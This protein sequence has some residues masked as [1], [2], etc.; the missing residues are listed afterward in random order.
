MQISD[1]FDIPERPDLSLFI[2]GIDDDNE[3]TVRKNIADFVVTDKLKEGLDGLLGSAGGMLE[4][5]KDIGRF[6]YGSFGSGKSHLMTI[7]GRMLGRKEIVYDLGRPALRELQARHPWMERRRCLVVRLNMMGKTSL[8]HALYE[9]FQTAMAAERPA[10]ARLDFTD[11][12]EVFALFEKDAAR[13]GGLGPALQQVAADNALAEVGGFGAQMPA[14]VLERAYHAFRDGDRKKRLTLAAA[15]LT[16]RN[17]GRVVRPDDL[18]VAPAAGFDRMARQAQEQGFDTIVWMIDELVIWLRGQTRDTYVSQINTLSAMV[19]H[20]SPRV[21]PFFVLVAVQTDISETC[22]NDLSE[23][24]FREQLSFISNRFRPA[25]HLEEQDLYEVCA[26]RVL[27]PRA[28]LPPQRRQAMEQAIDASFRQHD[29]L[30]RLLC[31]S[32]DLARVRR[33]YPFHP[34]ILRVLIDVTQALSRNRTAIAAL[35]GMLDAHRSLPIGRFLPLAALW[36]ILFIPDNVRALD[37]NVRSELSQRLS[38]TVQTWERLAGKVAAIS[39]DDGLAD[40]GTESKAQTELRQ[41]LRTAL[42]CQL[43]ERPYFPDGRA[44]RESVTGGTL[45]AFAQSEISSV[46][47]ATG[48]SR[49]T[50]Q[51][52]R[53]S[54]VAP[55]VTVGEGDDPRVDI[56]TRN[57]DIERVLGAAR[58]KVQHHH[59]FAWMRTLMRDVLGL[60]IGDKTEGKFKVT[61]RGTER[62]ARV[63]VTNVRTAPYA[64]SQNAFDPGDA[65]LLILVDYPFDEDER[66]GPQEDADAAERARARATQWTL[67]WLPEHLTATEHAA[68][69]NAAAIDIIRQ[70]RQAALADYSPNDARE[71]AAALEAFQAGRRLELES[72]LSR[73]FFERHRLVPLKAALDSAS[74]S[75]GD[76]TRSLDVLARQMLDARYPRHP[77]LG[78]RIG[79]AELSEVSDWVVRAAVTGQPAEPPRASGLVDALAV[80]L[81]IVFPG[82]GRVTARRDGEYLERVLAWAAGR[83]SFDAVELR[84]LLAAEDGWQMGFN[85]DFQD[86]FL[87][88]LLQVEGYE[89]QDNGRGL[90]LTSPRSLP[91]R[92]RLVKDE[93]V[94]APTWEGAIAAAAALLGTKNHADLPT[95]PAQARLVREIRD[96]V[97][98]LYGAVDT[99]TADLRRA[100]P[101]VQLLPADSARLATADALKDLFSAVQRTTENAPLC[102]YLAGLPAAGAATF[103]DACALRNALPLEQAALQQI[104][105]RDRHLLTIQTRGTPEEQ[106][107]TLTRLRGMLS[108]GVSTSLLHQKT[109]LWAAHTDSVFTAVIGRINDAPPAAPPVA[110]APPAAAVI[111]APPPV[112]PPPAAVAHP[113][114]PLAAVAH[115]A[116][117]PAAVAHPAVPPAA[118]PAARPALSLTLPADGALAALAAQLPPLLAAFGGRRVRLTVTVEDA[119]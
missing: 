41:I 105:S 93:V 69:T 2:V 6:V 63:V 96:I 88:W 55:E 40:T 14:P 107:T 108:D 111:P 20:D 37:N 39:R 28:D 86:F 16:W 87:F 18:W 80:P 45:Y 3:A 27:A 23:Q 72:A 82:Q 99:F 98:R 52:R 43:S 92:F 60:P 84:R 1:L 67:C 79:P 114:A 66:S 83:T 11:E 95:S 65:D 30:V 34:A 75:G 26:Q 100:L 102:R 117:P 9:A 50:R 8:V 36:E 74:L 22:P 33:I 110:V 71:I 51:L 17:H 13:L 61:W 46:S 57:L 89:A 77:V 112:A 10:A 85:K 25:L 12:A 53:L 4:R 44:L 91:E 103:R 59:R 118:G 109:G 42:L 70:T 115:P 48:R 54:G 97:N 56:R 49:V 76:R 29:K 24:G 90:T 64:G 5:N 68:L 94:D 58:D 31:G 35:Y 62:T 47:E 119:P 81:Q 104:L 101:P 21:L 113:A 38:H 73:C 32:E 116:A 19:D 15:L 7:L 106:Q 78:R